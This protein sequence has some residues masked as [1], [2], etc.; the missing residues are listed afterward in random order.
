MLATTALRLT[1]SSGGLQQVHSGRSTRRQP[2]ACPGHTRRRR[3]GLCL[4]VS[5]EGSRAPEVDWDKVEKE[6]AGQLTSLAV[7]AQ[8]ERS[9]L[10][11][12]ADTVG[13]DSVGNLV[14]KD[15]AYAYKRVQDDTQRAKSGLKFSKELLVSHTCGR[16]RLPSRSLPL[17]RRSTRLRRLA[18][19]RCGHSG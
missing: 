17:S 4:A 12:Y 3:S 16:C 7:E 9:V 2:S 13:A 19:C 8:S 18:L 1:A 10:D 5:D 11:S 6:N 15:A 14:L